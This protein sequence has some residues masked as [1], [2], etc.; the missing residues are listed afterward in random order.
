M[1]TAARVL[2][3]N[4]PAIPELRRTVLSGRITVSGAAAA[5][6]EP[7]AVQ[8]G[9]ADLALRREAGTLRQAVGLV[10]GQDGLTGGIESADA[11]P[12]AVQMHSLCFI[13]RRLPA[14]MNS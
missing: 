9:V 5:I 14:C 12:V 2:G 8:R 4:S 7:A 10:K 11:I 13:N 6:K 3:R 1:S